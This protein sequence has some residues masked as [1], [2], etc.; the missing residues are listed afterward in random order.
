M[1]PLLEK[2]GGNDIVVKCKNIVGVSETTE[3]NKML[4]RFRRNF[5]RV[6]S[7]VLAYV[8]GLNRVATRYCQVYKLYLSICLSAR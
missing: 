5:E 8:Y 3:A 4:I 6:G 2:G 1:V 7:F